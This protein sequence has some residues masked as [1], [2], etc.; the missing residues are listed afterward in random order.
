M[1]NVQPITKIE[2]EELCKTTSTYSLLDFHADWCGPCQVMKP[3]V[4]NLAIDEDLLGK[5][6]FYDV[7]VDQ[8]NEMAFEFKVRGIPAFTLVKTNEGAP[9]TK[10][11]S[12]IGSQSA[13]DLKMKILKAISDDQ[14]LQTLNQ[15]V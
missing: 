11:A 3:I 8:E 4:D 9:Y 2:F 13:F 10:V 1:I 7:N 15:I 14:P 12:F 6:S 5:C